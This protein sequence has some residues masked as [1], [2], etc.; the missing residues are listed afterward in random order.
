MIDRYG[1]PPELVPDF[2]GLK[3][4][5]SDNIPGVPGIGDKTASDLLQRF[6]SLE[7]VLGT[8]DQISGAKRKENLTDHAD[9]ARLSK[10]LATAKRDIPLDLDLASIR[11][12]GAGPFEAAR[13]L[14]AV[15]T[16]RPAAP[17]RG[18]ARLGRRAAPAPNHRLPR[19]LRCEQPTLRRRDV[20]RR[21]RPA[22]A[23]A[24]VALAVR[25][26]DA[27]EGALFGE[28]QWRFGV[29]RGAGCRGVI[30]GALHR[31]GRDRRR[32]RPA[33]GDRARREVAGERAPERS[34][35]TPRSVPTCSSRPAA[36]T[37]SA[38]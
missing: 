13:H 12:T 37:R 6:G 18:G 24:E 10:Q 2:I 1:I 34:C 19:P 23:Y 4:D 29:P 16:A 20:R 26:P 22:A 14:P 9:D 5:T 33:A 32:A 31:P 7:N 27:P 30:A 36:P 35:T 11:R 28:T 25:P 3:G 38:S 17:S 15:R 8:I 21:A